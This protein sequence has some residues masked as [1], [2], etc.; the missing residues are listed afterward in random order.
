MS[1][2]FSVD[3]IFEIAEQIER[4]GAAFYLKAAETAPNPRNRRL[5]L[6]LAAKERDHEKVFVEMRRRLSAREREPVVFDPEN[7]AVLY[8]QAFA[9][10]HVFDLTTDPIEFFDGGRTVPEILKKATELE[11]DTV[12]FY[13]GM[14]EM[15]PERLGRD[16]VNEIIKE[17]MGHIAL[18]SKELELLQSPQSD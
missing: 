17:E 13:L 3:E 9:G 11:R 12:V 4:N 1:I 10:G 5:M 14:Q 16:R 2:N 8:L 7:Q 18:L 15:V 6:D